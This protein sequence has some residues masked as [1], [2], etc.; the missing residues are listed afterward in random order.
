VPKVY[1]RLCTRRILV[2]EWIDGIK[3]SDAS[4]SILRGS[5]AAQEAF[6]T[7]LLRRAF[8]ADPVSHKL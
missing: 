8:H 3:L 5:P 1:E 6:L 4:L 2:S 7:Q